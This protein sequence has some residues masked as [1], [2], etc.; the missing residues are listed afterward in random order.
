ML[1]FLTLM[2]WEHYL[3]GK[4]FMLYSDHEALRFLHNQRRISNDMYARW[5]TYLQWFPIRIVYKVGVQNKVVN[6]LSRRATLLVTL[7]GSLNSTVWKSC[8]SMMRI[9]VRYGRS[10][11]ICLLMTFI[12]MMDFWWKVINFAFLGL[13][14]RRRWFRICMEE[15]W[16]VT[17]VT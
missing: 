15:F 8:T 17:G 16:L 10:V 13:H 9:S 5:V 2:K 6:A 1:F 7:K 3:I 14:C 12:F 11:Q 4:E